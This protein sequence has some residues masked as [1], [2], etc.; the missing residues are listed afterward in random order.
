M[1]EIVVYL[2]KDY[3]IS[4]SI[5]VASESTKEQITDEVNKVFDTWYYYDINTINKRKI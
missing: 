5:Y 2:K 3:S 1:V 4:K